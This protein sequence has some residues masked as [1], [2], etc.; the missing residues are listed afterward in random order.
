MDEYCAKT[1]KEN[2]RMHD[3]LVYYVECCG[4]FI[5]T[6]SD[7]TNDTLYA[8]VFDEQEGHYSECKCDGVRV[9]SGHLELSLNDEWF[10]LLGGMVIMNATLYNLCECLPQYA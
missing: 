4:G 3:I 7:E 9:S 8:L 6:S 5:D 2:K 10:S 1:C